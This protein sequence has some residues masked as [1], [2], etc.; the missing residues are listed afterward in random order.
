MFKA[1]WGGDWGVICEE[2]QDATPSNEY[3]A[4]W[5]M[6]YWKKGVLVYIAAQHNLSE[7]RASVNRIQLIGKLPNFMQA[8][9]CRL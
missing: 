2:G 5:A 1:T 7:I 4:I 8:V 9:M 6:V 3:G